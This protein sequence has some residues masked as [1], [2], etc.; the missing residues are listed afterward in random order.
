VQPGEP[1]GQ[2]PGTPAKQLE[3]GREEQAAHKDRVD[4]DGEG[5][6]D[7]E[8]FQDDDVRRAEDAD[9]DRK[10]D[11]SRGDDAADRSDAVA[12]CRS[13]GAPPG[14]RPHVRG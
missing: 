14:A 13:V 11:R 6:A 7:T 10:E 2:P 12:N 4:E 9:R 8:D 3:G 1:R 5:G